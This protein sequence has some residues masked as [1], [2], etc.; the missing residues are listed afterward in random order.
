MTTLYKRHDV[1]TVAEV[2]ALALTDRQQNDAY[3]ICDGEICTWHLPYAVRNE[4]PGNWLYDYGEIL[5][6][7]KATVLVP[8]EIYEGPGGHGKSWHIDAPEFE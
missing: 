5:D 7:D 1:T 3:V 6:G 4:K 8:V 2:N